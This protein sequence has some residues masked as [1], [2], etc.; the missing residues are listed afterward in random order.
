MNGQVKRSSLRAHMSSLLQKQAAGWAEKGNSGWVW[1][2]ARTLVAQHLL[3][4]ANRA[5]AADPRRIHEQIEKL[6]QAWTLTHD[7]RVAIQLA[8]TYD[9]INRNEDALVVLRQAFRNDPRAIRS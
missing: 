3:K 4:E 1:R 2:R 7:P 5:G 9:L 6:E 8:T